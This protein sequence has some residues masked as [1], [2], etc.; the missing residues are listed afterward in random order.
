MMISKKINLEK[1]DF[2]QLP[3]LEQIHA[4]QNF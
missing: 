1:L 3:E 2:N 4:S